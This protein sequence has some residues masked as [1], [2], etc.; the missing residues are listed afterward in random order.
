MT[1]HIQQIGSHRTVQPPKP[2]G[3]A[4]PRIG[5][6]RGPAVP[7]IPVGS[8]VASATG[9]LSPQNAHRHQR[10]QL[11]LQSAFE[12]RVK[13]TSENPDGFREGDGD[14]MDEAPSA[15]TLWQQGSVPAH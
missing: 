3:G 8:S 9:S 2:I 13:F 14:L 4:R 1:R 7:P 15:F 5:Q 10:F 12:A 6:H 11:H